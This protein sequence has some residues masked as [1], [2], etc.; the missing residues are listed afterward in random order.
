[1]AAP[2]SAVNTRGQSTD[3]I[4]LT[5]GSERIKLAIGDVSASLDV[6]AAWQGVATHVDDDT[7][8]SN[9]GIVI[10]GGVDETDGVTPRR[11]VVDVNGR[12]VTAP[13]V[14]PG[15]FT[16]HSGTIAVADTSEEIIGSDTDRKYVL[17]QNQDVTFDLWI[18]F[19]I[20]A[21]KD[22]PSVRIPPLG[23]FVMEGTFITSQSVTAISGSQIAFTAKEAV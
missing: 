23:A 13:V 1:M 8:A 2:V 20:A 7:F 22:Q 21:V 16:D 5:D 15:A 10:I 4:Y 6:N 11:T 14:A 17:I 18:N 9:D 12:L 19:G 3:S